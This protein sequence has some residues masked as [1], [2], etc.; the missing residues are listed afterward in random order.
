MYIRI[1]RNRDGAPTQTLL[2]A[3]RLDVHPLP[4][5]PHQILLDIGEETNHQ[6]VHKAFDD[7]YVMN[8]EGKTVD[9]YRWP[10]EATGEQDAG[11]NEVC[12]GDQVAVQQ[13]EETWRV[14]IVKRRD[15]EA[16][17]EF[18]GDEDPSFT[19]LGSVPEDQIVLL[20]AMKERAGEGMS[21]DGMM[22]ELLITNVSGQEISFDSNDRFV[23]E[24]SSGE[25]TV[26]GEVTATGD[27][28]L[29]GSKA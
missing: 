9:T 3:D 16:V 20:T 14:G 12:T 11:G 10:V 23:Y 26:T 6:R 21:H 4:G 27:V 18:V 8:D 2:E 7:V 22:N 29:S 1:V 19:V 24:Q 17:V 28:E 15:R 5:E 13:D 25:L